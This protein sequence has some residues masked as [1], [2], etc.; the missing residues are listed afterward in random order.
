MQLSHQLSGSISAGNVT[1]TAS[2]T[3]PAVPPPAFAALGYTNLTDTAVP[4]IAA[5]RYGASSPL[6]PDV[7]CSFIPA[8]SIS[9]SGYS[10]NLIA[11]S[12][13]P[14]DAVAERPR[15]NRNASGSTSNALAV[16]SARV[17]VRRGSLT[18][19]NDTTAAPYSG[20]VATFSFCSDSVTVP[21]YVSADGAVRYVGMGTGSSLDVI[22]GYNVAI[23]P[24]G[25]VLYA[26]AA[27]EGAVETVTLFGF[28]VDSGAPVTSCKTPFFS[29]PAMGRDMF[30]A[31]DDA[32][33]ALIASGCVDQGCVQP[34]PIGFL[35]HASCAFTPVA[36]LGHLSTNV[37]SF[38]SA[39]Y[40]NDTRQVVFTLANS[41][42][43][44]PSIIA[45][46]LTD[47]SFTEF[48]ETTLDNIDSLAYDAASG[49]IYGIAQAGTV[50]SLVSF[51]S[52]GFD[53][54][55]VGVISRTA[56]AFNG[57]GTVGDGEYYFLL[58]DTRNAP[59][60]PPVLAAVDLESGQ[61]KSTTQIQNCEVSITDCPTTLSFQP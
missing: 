30:L 43:Q 22:N 41:S 4:L 60:T 17:A 11:G 40:N 61:L 23:D 49:L 16:D 19:R 45:L 37:G 6:I 32:T 8:H 34:V 7:P 21:G 12:N 42:S 48:N 5:Y 39:A 3:R 31:F 18:R 47:G 2:W 51:N 35:D 58:H 27:Y 10:G 13:A 20:I 36:S 44:P 50:A 53:F 55:T 1:L 14:I 15:C 28:A 24:V 25:R 29:P 56:E 9:F 54:R 38:E 26:L 33:G 52:L 57:L 59:L 46:N